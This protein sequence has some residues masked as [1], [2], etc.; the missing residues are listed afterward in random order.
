MKVDSK[1]V[2]EELINIHI[3]RWKEMPNIDLYIDQV[4]NLL[5]KALGECVYKEKEG[6][7]I[8]KNMINNYVKHNIIPPA[9]NKKYNKEHIAKLVMI[10]ILKTLYSITDISS[11]L[12]FMNED[13]DVETKY[14]L[15][16]DEVES[17]IKVVFEKREDKGGKDINI[18]KYMLKRIVYSF[19]NKLYIYKVL[20][21]KM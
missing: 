18:E 4:I 14:N 9:V 7:V 13:E 1:D 5:D 10:C 15:F 20:L 11:M 21:K 6:H 19:A 12:K 8:T 2:K 17:A 3:I 16:C